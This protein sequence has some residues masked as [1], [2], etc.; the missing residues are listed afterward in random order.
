[1]NY[2]A[3][4]ADAFNLIDAPNL[5]GT[6]ERRLLLAILERALLDYVG[7]DNKEYQEAEE[8]IFSPDDKEGEHGQFSFGWIC[9]E[10]DLDITD[11]RGKI[12]LMPRRGANR[13]AP[14]YLTKGYDKKQKQAPK[15]T[16]LTVEKTVKQQA[17]VINMFD[18]KLAV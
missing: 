8:W 17:R 11:I 16:G 3:I 6:P 7:N 18:Q 1:M 15:K 13:I 14:W 2:P 12:R 10:L 9:E 4:D 5:T